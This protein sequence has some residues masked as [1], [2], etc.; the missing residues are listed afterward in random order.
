MFDDVD[1]A[2]KDLI[3]LTGDRLTSARVQVLAALLGAE[4]ALT[5]NEIKSRLDKAHGINRVTVYRVLEW[6][7]DKKIA[8]KIS[9]DD[10]IWRFNVM[11]EEQGIEH[12]HFVCNACG[13]VLCLGATDKPLAL[14][15]PV[16]F[17]PLHVET[18]IKGLCDLC[19][20]RGRRKQAQRARRNP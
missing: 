5:H 2:A 6:L 17:E 11:A 1:A 7:T 13:R 8:H 3:R 15:L 18:T 10:R 14:D 19:G 9:G 20:A 12:P 4:R 16:G